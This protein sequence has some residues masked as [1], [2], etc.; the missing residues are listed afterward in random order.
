MTDEQ[1][2]D[3]QHSDPASD[4]ASVD[5]STEEHTTAEGSDDNGGSDEP[6]EF[7]EDPVSVVTGVGEQAPTP[8]ETVEQEQPE[9]VTEPLEPDEVAAAAV[10]LA[11]A[12]LIDDVGE[13][14]V[15]E[16]MGISADAPGVVTHLFAC[17]DKS[18]VGWQWAIAVARIPDSDTVT[19]N[20]TVLLPAEGALLSPE[21]LPWD[22]RVKPG[23]ISG[24][25]VLPTA[26][27]DPRLVPGYTADDEG[28][29]L[30]EDE[31]TPTQWELGLGRVRVLSPA[32][33]A[34]AARRWRK[35]AGSNKSRNRSAPLPCS[36][37]G[38]AVALAGPLAPAFALCANEF[39]EYDGHVVALDFGCG[40]HSEITAPES[41]ESA[42][43]LVVDDYSDSRLEQVDVKSLPEAEPEQ[44]SEQAASATDSSNDPA[45]ADTESTEDSPDEESAVESSDGD[46]SSVADESPSTDT[47]DEHSVEQ[48]SA[49]EESG[50]GEDDE[51]LDDSDDSDENDEELDSDEED[52]LDEDELDDELD[53]EDDPDL[54]ED[55]DES[56]ESDEDDESDDFEDDE[57]DDSDDDDLD[58]G[59]LAPDDDLDD[60]LDIDEAFEDEESNDHEAEGDE[61]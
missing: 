2:H 7:D 57:E 16:H 24:Q 33:Q 30:I 28:S 47:A 48:D 22:K 29:E 42:L 13:Q 3:D 53:D 55:D 50:D 25:D 59:D 44:A 54:D 26:P 5:E 17:L 51:E 32:A 38:Y 11:R 36:T 9:A 27:D 6:S 14:S 31:L 40:A 39:A 60:A 52:E 37:C 1:N 19:I 20:E 12:A 21:W 56:D 49:D 61:R 45:P 18:Y 15:G 41:R 23:D 34:K 58:E 4:A 10:E 43:P 8:T 46:D 35:P